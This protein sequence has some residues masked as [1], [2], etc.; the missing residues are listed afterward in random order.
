MADLSPDYY[1]LQLNHCGGKNYDLTFPENSTAEDLITNIE[2]L[3]QTPRYQ[4][5]VMFRGKLI[6]D[7]NGPFSSINIPQIGGK[8]MVLGKKNTPEEE[9]FMKDITELLNNSKKYE[10]EVQDKL[11]QYDT[12]IRKNFIEN[13]DQQKN[14]IVDMRKRVKF[15]AEQ[16]MKFL[17]KLDM[18]EIKS[19][20]GDA[21]RMRKNTVSKIQKWLDETD[22]FID[23]LDGLEVW[24]FI[25]KIFLFM[26]DQ[27]RNIEFFNYLCLF[28]HE[29]TMLSQS[30]K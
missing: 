23:V 24:G 9:K 26:H 30:K 6:T 16:Q 19:D 13:K 27:M 17:M 4:L 5:K 18:M 2:T 29:K 25:Y 3:L 10:K 11:I 14:I 21:K 1:K 28:W 15:L 22:K 8:L 7:D 12:S 20:F